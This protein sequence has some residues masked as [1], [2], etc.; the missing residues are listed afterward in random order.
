MFGDDDFNALEAGTAYALMRHGQDRQTA[1]LLAGLRGGGETEVHVDVHVHQDDDQTARPVNAL[2]FSTVAMPDDMDDYIGQ[3]PMK[4][5]LEVY[6]Q[7]AEARNAALPHILLASGYPGVG[8][9]TLARLIA[10]RLSVDIWELVP[11]F[12]I[13]TLVEAA[14]RL[15]D[16]D[17][18][19]IDEVHRLG[20]RGGEILLK[21]L[22]EKVAFMPDGDVIPLADITVIAATT[23][24]D[25][26]LEP[27]LDRFKIKPYFQPYSWGELGAIAVH[28]AA[29]H[30][31]LDSI[32]DDLAVDIAAACRN[33]PRIIE[34]MVLAARDMELTFGRPPTSAELLEFLEVE[35]DGLTRVHIHYLTAMRQYFPRVDKYG[36]IEY[37]VGE[38][39][40]KQILRETKP[41][42]QRVEAFLVERGLIDRTPRG[43]RLTPA[44]IARAEGFIAAGK[45]AANSG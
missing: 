45:G 17:I 11:P 10:K 12:N 4:R 23:E 28:F 30:D 3:G 22:E 32:D 34:E 19:F 37:V 16:R 13:Y 42:I 24:P 25:A 21:V 43:R 39:A 31:C 18:L 29:R 20:G 44:G 9:T 2:D 1:D 7:S 6:I 26:L 38:A 36:E 14:Q 15:R 8:K 5:Q 33:T 27:V 41:G 40:I 35:P